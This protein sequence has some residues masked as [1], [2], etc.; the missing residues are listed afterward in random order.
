MARNLPKAH[1]RDGRNRV[2]GYALVA[3]V[4]LLVAVIGVLLAG[5]GLFTDEPSSDAE[6]DYQ[7]LLDG[8]KKKPNDPSVLM[9]LAETEYALGKKTDALEHAKRSVAKAG[10]QPAFRLRYAALL[11]QDGDKVEARKQAE[12]EIALETPGDPEPFFLLAQIDRAEKKYREAQDNM[13][14]GLAIEPMAADMIILYADILA[15]SGNKEE[16]ITQYK[17]A[18]RFL[19]DDER[20]IRGLAALGVKVEPSTE[21]TAH[22]TTDTNQ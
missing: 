16:A 17:S 14:K 5:G 7:L 18:L 4:V 15:E 2:V 22:S 13:E 21:T 20:A 6:R 19:P 3:A 12:A 9:T 10:E 11:L 1:R 8:L